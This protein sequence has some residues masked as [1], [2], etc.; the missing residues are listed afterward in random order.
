MAYEK[1]KVELD[2]E[3]ITIKK[4]ALHSSL[5]VPQSYKFKRPELMKLKEIEIGKT[6]K[7]KGNEFRMTDLRK[8]R[9]TLATNL[10]KK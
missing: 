7:F 9:I 4:G 8:K 10:M 5:K 1:E 3:K 6:F 2:G